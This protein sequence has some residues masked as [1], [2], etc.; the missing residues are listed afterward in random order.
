MGNFFLSQPKKGRI[1]VWVGE[2][3]GEAEAD[4]KAE[5]LKKRQ[6]ERLKSLLAAIGAG[7]IDEGYTPKRFGNVKYTQVDHEWIYAYTHSYGCGLLGQFDIWKETQSHNLTL[8]GSIEPHLRSKLDILVQKLHSIYK[9]ILS[10]C[11]PS[12][13]AGRRLHYSALL[14]LHLYLP[15]TTKYNLPVTS[16]HLYYYDLVTIWA[17]VSKF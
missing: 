9:L 16:C 13:P 7:S 15:R 8:M 14:H 12:H 1:E 2:I 6:Q 5:R 3:E 10:A 11:L 17:S 4:A